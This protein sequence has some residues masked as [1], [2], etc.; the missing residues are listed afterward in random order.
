MV[1]PMFSDRMTTSHRAR[2]L[3]PS[4]QPPLPSQET[5]MSAKLY[6]FVIVLA[7]LPAAVAAQESD[8]TLKGSGPTGAFL[9]P[10]QIDRWF[11]DG[12]KG[13][14]IVVHVA[15][16]EFDPLLGLVKTV[17]KKDETVVADVDDLG[18]ES[19]F[20]IR[21]PEKGEYKIR[22]RAYK[23]QAGGNYKLQV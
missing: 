20:M 2:F 17:G 8:R 19:R 18:T 9:T 15:S 23:D 7:L 13:E 10:G 3:Q 11:F 14:T 4:A 1:V 5:I 21:L 16:K 22:V 12:E 6:P